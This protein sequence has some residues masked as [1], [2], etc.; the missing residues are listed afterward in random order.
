MVVMYVVTCVYVCVFVVVDGGVVS[1][2]D[3]AVDFMLFVL[4]VCF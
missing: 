1:D 3:I 2:V 4:L